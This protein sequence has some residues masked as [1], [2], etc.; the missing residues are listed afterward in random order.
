VIDLH[1]LVQRAVRTS[2]AAGAQL[3]VATSDGI[4]AAS[5]G[6]ADAERGASMSD[7]TPLQVGSISKTLVAAAW[8]SA[9]DRG[10]VDL[11]A[12]LS[13]LAPAF[14]PRDPRARAISARQA[15][16]MSSGLDTGPYVEWTADCVDDYLAMV[17]DD[18]LLFA[19][20]TA[21]AYSG[22]GFVLAARALEH[23]L[24][25][26]WTDHVRDALLEPLGM[27]ATR[28]GA[29]ADAAPG[30]APAGAG[31]AVDRESSA[32]P[33]LAPTGTTA[34]STASDLARLARAMAGGAGEAPLTTAARERMHSPV[35]SVDVGLIASAWGLGLYRR[36][37]AAPSGTVLVAGH[38]GR[39][40]Q[41]VCDVVWLPG[42]GTGYAVTTNT[43]ARAG[44]LIH[45]V[46][47]A[48][49]PE[50]TGAAD[51]WPAPRPAPGPVDDAFAG[52]FRSPAGEFVVAP[53]PQGIR[54][55]VT[56]HPR[57]GTTDAWGETDQVLAPIGGRRFLPVGEGL[58]ERRLQEV[59]F[60]ED[61]TRVYD[62]LACGVRV[63]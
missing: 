21:F 17:A 59:W 55:T 32:W 49:L 45:L 39:W 54:L 42:T 18:P 53:H 13:A 22:V 44:A 56:R 15:L 29:D 62:G 6:T 51:A 48:L 47:A 57:P 46:G 27:H 4:V 34:V 11:D 61:L 14:R 12:P 9:A 10:L 30:H 28:L 43:P 63:G 58:D 52:A 31:F 33:V 23:V 50:L 3:A 1:E 41:G 60:S 20:G 24:G 38:G 35:V 36:E 26:A 37:V 16:S 40:R 5:A 19:P 8:A 7:V 25:A 2:G